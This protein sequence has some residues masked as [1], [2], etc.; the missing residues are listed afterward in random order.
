M[1]AKI[2]I[3]LEVEIFDNP[4]YDYDL[5]IAAMTLLEK[6]KEGFFKERSFGKQMIKTEYLKCRELKL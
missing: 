6:G 4:D 5:E 1:K 3:E 2:T